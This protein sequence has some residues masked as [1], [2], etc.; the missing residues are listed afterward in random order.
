[1]MNCDETR[2]SSREKIT[3]DKWR[4]ERMEKGTHHRS[5]KVDER[6]GPPGGGSSKKTLLLRRRSSVSTSLTLEGRRRREKSQ[7]GATTK[8]KMYEMTSSSQSKSKEPIERR[9]VE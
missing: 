6:E 4:R 5:S 9:H 7:P 2:G 1:M 3:R 8:T